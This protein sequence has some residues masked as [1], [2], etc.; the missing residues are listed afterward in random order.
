V[1]MNFN[2]KYRKDSIL[3]KRETQKQ[4]GFLAEK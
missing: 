4:N 2:F 1:H 3:E